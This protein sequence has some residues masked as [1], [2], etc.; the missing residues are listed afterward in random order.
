M[1]SP[2]RECPH[3]NWIPHGAEEE[4]E[5]LQGEA[6]HLPEEAEGEEVEEMAP[7]LVEV[8]VVQVEEEVGRA[9]VGGE[10]GMVVG[11]AGLVEDFQ[12]EMVPEGKTIY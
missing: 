11:V 7:V 6:F 2:H 10:E 1:G 3:L 5:V 4:I 12:E 9:L 8:G